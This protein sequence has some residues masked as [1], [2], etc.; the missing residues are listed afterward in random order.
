MYQ[1]SSKE[2]WLNNKYL[3]GSSNHSRFPV[4]SIKYISNQRKLSTH[5]HLRFNHN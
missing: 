1:N 5:P 4:K 3:T 2:S